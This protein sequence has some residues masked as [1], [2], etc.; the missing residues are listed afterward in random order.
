MLVGK[1]I[2]PRLTAWETHNDAIVQKCVDLLGNSDNLQITRERQSI[3]SP[4]DSFDRKLI[5]NT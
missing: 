2:P 1:S 3:S 4:N 5:S